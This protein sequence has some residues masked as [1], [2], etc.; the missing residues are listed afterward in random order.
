M[1]GEVPSSKFASAKATGGML[2]ITGGAP[3]EMVSVTVDVTSSPSLSSDVTVIVLTI[4][5]PE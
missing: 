1:L 4:S 5:P 3:S 2:S